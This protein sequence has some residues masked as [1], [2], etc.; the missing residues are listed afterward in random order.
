[1][2]QELTPEA[3]KSLI[4]DLQKNSIDEVI[5][6]RGGFKDEVQRLIN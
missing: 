4:G 5:L 3:R 6:I 1:M 2:N